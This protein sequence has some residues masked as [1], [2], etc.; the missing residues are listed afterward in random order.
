MCETLNFEAVLHSPQAGVVAQL[1]VGEELFLAQRASDRAIEA[2]RSN[3]DLV[4][5]IVTDLVRLLPCMNRG[6]VYLGEVRSID[7]GEVKVHVRL[8]R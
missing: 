3:G 6:F 1:M 8:R 4:G 7:E 5:T 2:S